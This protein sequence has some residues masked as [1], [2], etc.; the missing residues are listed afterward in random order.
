MLTDKPHVINI[1]VVSFAKLANSVALI[2]IQLTFY[3]SNEY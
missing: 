1:S 2:K 3:I